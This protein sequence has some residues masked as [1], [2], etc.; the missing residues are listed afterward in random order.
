MYNLDG[1][2]ESD[3]FVDPGSSSPLIR[4]N[5]ERFVDPGSSSP[6]IRETDVSSESF[7]AK[8][9]DFVVGIDGDLSAR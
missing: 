8:T 9:T 5:E 1:Q 7:E 4:E 6:L 2:T 3:R